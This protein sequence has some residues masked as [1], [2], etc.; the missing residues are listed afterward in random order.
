M[1]L[2]V[3]ATTAACGLVTD[4]PVLAVHVNVV[5]AASR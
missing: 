2:G 4:C 3:Y 1:Q 5:T